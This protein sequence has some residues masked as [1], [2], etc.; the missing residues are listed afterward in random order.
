MLTAPLAPM[1]V[2]VSKLVVEI[3]NSCTTSCEKFIDVPPSI[4]SLMVPPSMVRRVPTPLPAVAP[5]VAPN[6]LT[7][8]IALNCET[9]P[10][11]TDTPGSIA[12][13]CNAERPFN[14]RS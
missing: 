8:N 11:T 14:G 4:S 9:L 3:W 12:A 6:T 2:E 5:A 7:L 13:S 10:G 1:P